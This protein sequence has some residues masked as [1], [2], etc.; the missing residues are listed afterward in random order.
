M[1][2]PSTSQRTQRRNTKMDEK[3]ILVSPLKLLIHSIQYGWGFHC[4]SF[5]PYGKIKK[6][7]KKAFNSSATHWPEP[8]GL[9]F[10]PPV[11]LREAW[12]PQ[13]WWTLHKTP[14]FPSIHPSLLLPSPGLH[15]PSV[16]M[17]PDFSSPVKY[18]FIQFR[19]KLL[20]CCT[21][22]VASK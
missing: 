17:V 9:R 22:P 1:Q 13:L 20:I 11:R 3:L 8:G 2:T 4:N 18:S 15:S 16:T 21:F 12:F 5:L 19:L 7:K 6:K 14:A 10:L